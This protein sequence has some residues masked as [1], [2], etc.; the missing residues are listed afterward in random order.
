[1]SNN[2]RTNPMQVNTASDSRLVSDTTQVMISGIVIAPTNATW[3]CILKNGVGD[4]IFSGNN[5]YAPLG[6]L[7]VTPFLVT[8]LV[9]NTL[10]N[11]SVLIYTV[12]S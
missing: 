2:S 6:I 5:N 11:C 4:I 9:V 12:P 7:P 10:T 8:G 3:S 1:M